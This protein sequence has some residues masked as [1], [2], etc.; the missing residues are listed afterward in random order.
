MKNAVDKADEK[1]QLLINQAI[2]VVNK[3]AK[4]IVL[5]HE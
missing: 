3:T 5:L 4:A 2:A 1:L